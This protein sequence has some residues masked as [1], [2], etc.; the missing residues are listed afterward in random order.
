MKPSAEQIVEIKTECRKRFGHERVIGIDLG[1]PLNLYVVIAAFGMREASDYVDSRAA[2]SIQAQSALVAERVLWP[3]PAAL[4]DVRRLGGALDAKIEERFREL[5][6]WSPNMAVCQPFSA[7]SAPPGFAS[8]DDLA[9]KAAGLIASHPHSKLWSVWNR[10]NGLSLVIAGP[11][12]DVYTAATASIG[13]ANRTRRG[14]LTCVLS[15]VK[16]LVVWSPK[17]FDALLDEAPGR[18]EDLANPF[19]EMGGASATSSATF[20]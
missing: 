7:Q 12:E 11:E 13:E 4:A 5:L 1:Q 14:I 15:F 17:P 9:T 10:D 8:R 18:A 6:G 3:E 19:L 16:P 20:L 2:S